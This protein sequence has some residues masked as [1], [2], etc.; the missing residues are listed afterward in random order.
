MKV[1]RVWVLCL[2]VMVATA[3]IIFAQSVWAATT[4]S[5]TVTTASDVLDGADGLCSLR[6]AVY[7]ANN[8]VPFGGVAGECAAGSD[9]ETDVI[10]LADGETY[11]LSVAGADEDQTTTGD[12]DIV[13]N[14]AVLD[15]Q[16]A[17]A[18]GGSATI[19]ADGIDRVLHILS[20]GVELN[21]ITL[22]NGSIVGGSGGGIYN[23][24]GVVTLN[25]GEILNNHGTI[26]GGIFNYSSGAGNGLAALNDTQVVLNTAA[27]GG[28]IV[29]G[30][31]F[32]IV[33]LDGVTVRANGANSSGGGVYIDGGTLMADNST[34][35]LNTALSGGGLYAQASAVVTITNSLIE[36]ND[37][38]GGPGGGIYL[39]EED[40]DTIDN[41]TLQNSTVDGNTATTRGGGIY[42]RSTSVYLEIE[43]TD[44][45]G[46]EAEDGGAISGFSVRVTGGTFDGNSATNEGGAINGSGALR[47]NDVTFTN[48]TAM[49]GGAIQAQILIA[50][51]IYVENNHATTE[52]GG[53]YVWHSKLEI[54]NSEFI[55]NTAGTD[56]GGLYARDGGGGSSPFVISQSVFA[57]NEAT[58]NGGGIFTEKEALSVGNTTISSNSAQNGGGLYIDTTAVVSAT[59]VTIALNM[60]GQD[61]YK[62]GEMVLQNS[63]IY[64]PDLPNCTL[65]AT[66]IIS[67]GNNLSD[68]ASCSGLTQPTDQITPDILL[69][70]LADNGGNT[71]THALQAGSP[72]IDTGDAAACAGPWVSG[73]DQRGVPRIIGSAC[74]IGAFEKGAVIFLPTV[75]K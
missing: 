20:A 2:S 42:G 12:L 65:I 14:T 71:L 35:N 6:E 30:G 59:N 58:N 24:G 21:N 28:G 1:R 61:L 63:I 45:S 36:S 31:D 41:F 53:A 48:N 11:L 40:T 8:N 74:D 22:T 68:D 3:V 38:L 54:Y 66:P 7:A 49:Q 51:G 26:G 72:A 60:P 19:D 16:F 64:T 46:N 23:D 9:S 50:N 10:T 29:S 39:L 44:F 75:L 37:A 18:N 69:D 70:P 17:V 13:D 67:L 4:A 15:I 55:S 62:V 25:G 47:A 33:T 32:A 52:G 5:L 57:N 56:G 27:A 73:V 34:I 43:N